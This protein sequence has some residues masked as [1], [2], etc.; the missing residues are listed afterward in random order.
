MI[1]L[2]IYVPAL[3][4]SFEFGLQP[5]MKI[6]D[7]IDEITSVIIQAKKLPSVL[8]NDEYVCLCDI[9]NGQVLPREKKLEDCH[10]IEGMTLML[11]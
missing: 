5:A 6:G 9:E 10:L 3:Y 11:L 4:E 2:E 8:E 7:L 1:H